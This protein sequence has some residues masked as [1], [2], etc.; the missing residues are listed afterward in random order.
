[1]PLANSAGFD[2]HRF[3]QESSGI[4]TV[5]RYRGFGTTKSKPKTK[6]KAE[7][8]AETKTEIGSKPQSEA[9]FGKPGWIC[10][11]SRLR[12]AGYDVEFG[13]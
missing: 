5:V 8:E 10:S 9:E 3:S 1:M 7:S 2:Y 13:R 12:A 11:E 6:T 4:G